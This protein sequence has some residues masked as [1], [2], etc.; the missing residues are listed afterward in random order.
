[1]AE[2]REK[3]AAELDEEGTRLLDK[4]NVGEAIRLYTRAIKADRSYGPAYLNRSKAYRLKGSVRL[5]REDELNYNSLAAASRYDSA[6]PQRPPEKGEV[7]P[8]ATQE[9][10]PE[11]PEVATP[12]PSTNEGDS[13]SKTLEG[14]TSEEGDA[15]APLPS[16]PEV[17]DSTDEIPVTSAQASRP[18]APGQESERAEES[19]GVA[20]EI[21]EGEEESRITASKPLRVLS[22]FRFSPV[23]SPATGWFLSPWGFHDSITYWTVE[24][25]LRTLLLIGIFTVVGTLIAKISYCPEDVAGAFWTGCGSEMLAFALGGAALGG[26]ISILFTWGLRR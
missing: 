12:V 15:E 7:E 9:K 13:A 17:V 23:D 4:G 21:S 3:T 1:M 6:R 11:Q 20:P 26:L 5:A 25:F 8:E 22:W 10:E 18:G 19:A 2:E 14:P 16:V 24:R